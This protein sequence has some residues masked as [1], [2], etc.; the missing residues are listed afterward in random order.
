M[1]NEDASVKS[2]EPSQKPVNEGEPSVTELHNALQEAIDNN[3]LESF[4]KLINEGKIEGKNKNGNTALSLAVEFKLLAL[5]TL[6]IE[7]GANVLAKNNYGNGPLHQL[8]FKVTD[9]KELIK[10]IIEKVKDINIVNDKGKTKRAIDDVNE[11]GETALMI[12]ALKDNEEV[13]KALLEAG[14]SFDIKN[15]RSGDNPLHQAAR[16][17]A[18]KSMEILLKKYPGIVNLTNNNDYTAL[19]FAA[20]NGRVAAVKFLIKNGANLFIKCKVGTNGEYSRTALELAARNASAARDPEIAKAYVEIVGVLLQAMEKEAFANPEKQNEFRESIES[21]L[22]LAQTNRNEKK[23]KKYAQDAKQAVIDKLSASLNNLDAYLNKINEMK[24]TAIS[25]THL[26]D[27]EP[28][29]FS[30]IFS[31]FSTIFSFFSTPPISEIE[32]TTSANI[33]SR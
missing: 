14:A 23:D 20:E 13:L 21:A 17:G 30:T 11:A 5:A 1:T 10:L 6:L 22:N 33:Q 16:T 24:T 4:K 2:S 27:S 29:C 15:K 26:E 25:D 7:Q 28:S 12:A 19:H 18:V 3:N 31:C 32:N 8:A 9:D